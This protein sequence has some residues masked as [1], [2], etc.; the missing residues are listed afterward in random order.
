MDKKTFL[1]V[2]FLV[3]LSIAMYALINHY[4]KSVPEPKTPEQ[5]RIG[6]PCGKAW[7]EEG[8]FK[9]TTNELLFI[10]VDGTTNIVSKPEP[11]E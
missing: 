10:R 6:C 1:T 8:K 7:L 5:W 9:V 11:Y 4:V 3:G 2:F